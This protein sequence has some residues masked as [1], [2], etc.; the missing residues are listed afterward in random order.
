MPDFCFRQR[1]TYQL[2]YGNIDKGAAVGGRSPARSDREE[3]SLGVLGGRVW[4]LV[5][6]PPLTACK[7]TLQDKAVELSDLEAAILTKSCCLVYEVQFVG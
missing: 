1:R 2:L 5:G 6:W 7:T 4:R 3:L